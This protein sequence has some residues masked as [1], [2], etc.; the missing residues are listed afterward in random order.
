[1]SA[2]GVSAEFNGAQSNPAVRTHR[3]C[4]YH[5]PTDPWRGY[6]PA[7]PRRHLYSS[8]VAP[9]NQFAASSAHVYNYASSE[10]QRRAERVIR[11]LQSNITG[12]VVW[13]WFARC[14]SSTCVGKRM[15]RRTLQRHGDGRAADTEVRKRVGVRIV[16]LP[17]L[18]AGTHTGGTAYK[19]T[20]VHIADRRRP[21]W[22]A[23]G[24]EQGWRCYF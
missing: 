24:Q 23:P 7:D 19:K 8:A 13:S 5:R 3:W 4:R 21:W 12:A 16:F 20:S 15:S 17:V 14:T 22:D 2:R 9:P 18:V 1:M 11:R 10:V 6:R